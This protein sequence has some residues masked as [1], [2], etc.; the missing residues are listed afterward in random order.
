MTMT[1]SDVVVGRVELGPA[2]A[3]FRSLGDPGRLA[4]LRRLAEGPARVIDLVE[5]LGLA[6][7]TVSKH[8][9]CLRDCGLV[10]SEPLGRA[11]LFRLTQPALLDLLAVAETVLATTGNAVALCPTYVCG[12]PADGVQRE[13]AHL[14]RG[15][16]PL[17]A[18]TRS[19]LMPRYPELLHVKLQMP[20]L[21]NQPL[22]RRD[23][24]CH[25]E[26]RRRPRGK[27]PDAGFTDTGGP[28]ANQFARKRP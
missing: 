21:G 13:Q 5:T 4:I 6:Q 19:F 26:S 27:T 17:L 23:K 15:R 10:S 7:S 28:D 14:V 11:S 1:A 12:P 3:L 22:S 8:L 20:G 9:I 24:K 25:P 18:R 16:R 2:A